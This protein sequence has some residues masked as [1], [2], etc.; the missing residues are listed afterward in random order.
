MHCGFALF[1]VTDVIFMSFIFLQSMIKS[2]IMKKK[3]RAALSLES[4]V[5]QRV[6]DVSN[7][8]VEHLSM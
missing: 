8:I 1:T 3:V 2:Y 6:P 7:E 4:E 5:L